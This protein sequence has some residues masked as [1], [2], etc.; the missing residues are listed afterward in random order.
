MS[1]ILVSLEL[2]S[3]IQGEKS[4]GS[5]RR[6]VRAE[7][8]LFPLNWSTYT[9]MAAEKYPVARNEASI[10]EKNIY[11]FSRGIYGK[12]RQLLVV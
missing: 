12:L 2:I 3:E 5:R 7:R 6:A 4:D 11:I 1:G 9:Q 10:L 8:N